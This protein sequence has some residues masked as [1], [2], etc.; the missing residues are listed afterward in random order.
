MI[1]LLLIAVRRDYILKSFFI[2][3]TNIFLAILAL[4]SKIFI[5]FFNIFFKNNN[6]NKI[7]KTNNATDNYNFNDYNVNNF[8]NNENNYDYYENNH[9]NIKINI[10][11]NG[12]GDNENNN[13]FKGLFSGIT[14]NLKNILFIDKDEEDTFIF[15]HLQNNS[16]F[17]NEY[18]D[19]NYNN[20]Y[21]SDKNQ[22]SMK[23][24]SNISN[25]SNSLTNNEVLQKGYLNK[26]IGNVGNTIGINRFILIL[27]SLVAIFTIVSYIFFGFEIAIAIILLFLMILFFIF[28]L[29]KMNKEK[30]DSE[31]SKEI[32]YALRQ[33]VT[34]LRSGKGLHDTIDSIANS[35]YGALSVEFSRVIKEIK[36]GENTEK[37]LVNM[38]KRVSSDGLNRAIQQII[39]TLR[40][41]GNLGSTLNIIAEDVS[42]DLQIKLKDY[43]QKL[44][45]FIMIYTF[46]AILGPVILLIMLMAAST[47]MGDIMPGNVVLIIYIF[48]FPMIVVFMGLM[49]KRLEPSL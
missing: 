44:N 23:N 30:Y 35:D 28:Y 31:I 21:N 4:F 42:Y 38:S 12:N 8:D 49:I 18:E 24:I 2:G 5:L 48:F 25:T 33:M 9:D 13:G 37:A 3:L 26:I 47:V 45:A 27:L 7:N 19:N 14:N 39:G 34:E 6:D 20:E 41:G 10:K 32:P 46:L 1:K 36:Y 11:N 43:S 17:N 29:P 22:Y 40:T 15:E 16:F